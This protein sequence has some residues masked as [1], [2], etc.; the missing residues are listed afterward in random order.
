MNKVILNWTEQNSET[1]TKTSPLSFLAWW[2]HWKYDVTSMLLHCL[3][4]NVLVLVCR[5]RVSDVSLFF[6]YKLFIGF[7][8]EWDL[9]EISPPC[10]T[11]N[12]ISNWIVVVALISLAPEILLIFTH[13]VSKLTFIIDFIQ[14]TQNSSKFVILTLD[15][16]VGQ[17]E[18][19][20]LP[21]NRWL[22]KSTS[23]FTDTYILI[24]QVAFF[25]V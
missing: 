5:K 15:Y 22:I 10:L 9:I 7:V 18:E 1:V 17:L 23:S 6:Y 24:K 13:K 25:V 12:W 16:L 21:I 11:L 2:I 20:A 19:L 4:S 14:V 8:C 3:T